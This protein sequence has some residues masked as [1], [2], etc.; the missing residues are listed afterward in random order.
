[1]A[2]AA[3]AVSL[4]MIAGTFRPDRSSTAPASI[5]ADI[6]EGLGFVW[7]HPVLRTL[8]L[9]LGLTNLASM[10]HLAVFVLF[11]V[12]PG[13]MG[14]SEAGFGVLFATTAIGGVL[15][16][17]IAPW[18][19]RVLGRWWSLFGSI[20]LIGAGLAVPA[21]TPGVIANGSAFVVVGGAGVVWNVITVSLRQRIT[22][23]RLLGRMNAAYRL[24]GWGTIPIG[25][26]LG[27][28]VAERFGLRTT[29]AVAA[30]LHLPILVGF[31]WLRSEALVA[32]DAGPEA[33]PAPPP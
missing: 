2:Y 4:A 11:A 7:R 21:A 28:L 9:M 8:G 24:L 18:C 29:F 17:Q 22:P 25:A 12:D 26:A 6:A 1:V 31:A 14:L 23:D 15:G 20:V 13:P 3:A 30:L 27:G 32:A 16:S 10:A 33:Q 5:R 19:E